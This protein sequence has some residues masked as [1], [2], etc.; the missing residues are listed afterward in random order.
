ME[1]R[2]LNP[3]ELLLSED[4]EGN[5]IA[6]TC[7]ACG[8]V[9]IVSSMLH[10]KGRACPNCGRSKGTVSGGEKA[11]GLASIISEASD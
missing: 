10:R 5:N 8:K 4:W 1:K 7:P 11:G 9:Y 3:N 6:V 2:N